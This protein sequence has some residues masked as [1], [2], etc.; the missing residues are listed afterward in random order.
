MAAYRSHATMCLKVYQLDP[1]SQ[2]QQSPLESLGLGSLSC[3]LS[4]NLLGSLAALRVCTKSACHSLSVTI[5]GIGTRIRIAMVLS[6]L[7]SL[8][9]RPGTLRSLSPKPI[10]QLS[11][12]RG[13]RECVSPHVT[14]STCA[15][16][17][18]WQR[19]WTLLEACWRSS[20]FPHGSR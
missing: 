16:T 1:L 14:R 8:R 3:Q 20:R 7:L 4:A 10:P 5:K 9:S 18:Q 11:T 13:P 6:P 2:P 12:R 19:P 15:L 17:G